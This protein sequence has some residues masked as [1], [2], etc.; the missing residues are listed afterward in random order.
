MSTPGHNLDEATLAQF[1][2]SKLLGGRDVSADESLLLSGLVDSLGVMT[3][4]AHLEET[5]GKPVP[6]EDVILE[7]FASINAIIAYVRSQ[8]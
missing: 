1:I 5:T 2:S 4:V 6:L 8:A 3:L 7:N